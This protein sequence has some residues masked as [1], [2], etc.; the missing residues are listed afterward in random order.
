MT[1][2]TTGPELVHVVG[3][4]GLVS[5]RVRDG[6]LRLRAVDGETLHVRDAHGGDLGSMLTIDLG[7]GSASLFED[8]G[9]GRFLDA[10]GGHSPELVIDLPRRATLVVETVSADIDADGLIGDQRYRTTS[11]DIGL[12]SASGR[13][14]IEAIS[15]DVDIRATGEAEVAARTVSGDIELRAG[16]LRSLRL[17]TTSGDI[18]VA[19]RLKGAGPFAIETVSGDARIAPAGDVRI[20]MATMSGDLRSEL[21]G[22]IEGGRGHRSLAIG[23]SG[24]QVTV[25]TMSG[26]LDVARPVP[27]LEPAG[28]EMVPPAP[29][30]AP[31][32]PDAPAP[33]AAAHQRPAAPA[34]NGAITA[35]YEDARLGILRSL[36]RGDIDVAEAGRRFEALDDGEPL[37]D[38][39]GAPVLDPASDTTRVPVVEPDHA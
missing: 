15:A 35:A 16:T 17:T 4:E 1:T 22:R 31:A 33:P 10:R 21:H 30:M 9:S 8:P 2:T 19:G 38:A 34:R 7:T 5:I 6:D 25:R 37:S 13:L 39:P 36:E 18:S 24:P 29:P 20:E 26:D 23:S 11:G 32:R 28:P 14:V 12:R 27:V 3:T